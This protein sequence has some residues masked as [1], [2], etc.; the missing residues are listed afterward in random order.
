MRMLPQSRRGQ[1]GW[2]LLCF[3]ILL[4]E[5]LY[6]NS[7]TS[8]TWDEGHHLFDGYTIWQQHDYDLN[9]EVP[10]L[11]K[12]AAAL[13]LLPMHL[14]VPR[15]MGRDSQ[16][17]AFLDGKAFLFTNNADA[18]LTYSRLAIACFALGTAFLVLRAGRVL[19]DAQT[20]LVALAFLIF[21]PTLLAHGA[22]VT[23]DAAITFF[24]MA[25]VLAWIAYSDKPNYSKLALAGAALG[26]SFATKFTGLLLLPVLFILCLLEAIR[27][28]SLALLLKRMAALAG[29]TFVAWFVLWAFYGFR[30]AIRPDGLVMNPTLPA[31]LASYRAIGNPW[32]ISTLAHARLLPEAFLWGLINT[33][34]TEQRDI[35]YL[36]GKLYRH[37]VWWYFPAAILIK[38]TLA[39][40]VMLGISVYSFCFRNEFRF[41]VLR[42]L[43]PVTVLLAVAM[44]SS[45]NIGIRHILPTYPFLY[46]IGAAYLV[47]FCHWRPGG[48]WLVLALWL[49]QAASS[50]AAAPEYIAYANEL[51]GRPNQVHRYLSDS[52]SDWGQQLKAA[53]GYL[54]QHHVADCWIAYTAEG[55]VD[56]NYYGIPCKPLPT[57]AS[58][59]WFKVP[60]E[61]PDEISGTVLISDDMLS[62][63]D[64]AP[65]KTNPYAQFRALKPAA[66]LQGGM[67]VYTGRFRV[68]DAAKVVREA[69]RHRPNAD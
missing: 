26:C 12:L 53:R 14:F 63:T 11:A 5:L 7:Q 20:G 44:A 21:D 67:F 52:N 54:Q 66:I 49:A 56:L 58:L 48:V 42:L 45:M 25:T 22:L 2:V 57:D 38:S 19:F 64:N 65:G 47:L 15:Q 69:N 50:L 13:P 32:L 35:G 59:W 33:K 10:P 68:E 46:V 1:A 9:P 28:R 60:M 61:V 36:F 55:A 17:E 3:V 16:L 27:H 30:Y 8:M 31:Y 39:F 34:F 51:W 43:V 29:A 4:S 24:F 40:L 23:T 41:Q 6:A 18:L 37:G 62:G